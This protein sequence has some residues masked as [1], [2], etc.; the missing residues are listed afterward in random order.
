[1]DIYPENKYSGYKK[2]FRTLHFYQVPLMLMF[3]EPKYSS[4]YNELPNF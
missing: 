1:M 4:F 2:F 3:M